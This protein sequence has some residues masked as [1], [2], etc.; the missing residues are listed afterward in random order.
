[1]RANQ[2]INIIKEDESTDLAAGDRFEYGYF[3]QS[4]GQGTVIE[5]IG[6]IG[7]ESIKATLDD[8]RTVKMPYRITPKNGYYIQKIQADAVKEA[9]DES[10]IHAYKAMEA[11][12]GEPTVEKPMLFVK[13]L[14]M[15][16]K[17]AGL[18]N[19][20][21]LHGLVSQYIRDIPRMNRTI[22]LVNRAIESAPSIDEI[23][24]Y[25]QQSQAQDTQFQQQQSIGQLQHELSMQQLIRQND[26]D[27]ADAEAML[28]MDFEAR[29]A[30]KE[31]QQ[32]LSL[33]AQERLAQIE[34]DIRNSREPE[35]ERQQA[36]QMA[37]MNHEHE[38][39]VIQVT[40]DGEY[41]KAKLEADYQIRIKE[42]ENI[43]NARDRQ[44]KL[45]TINANKAKELAVID[46]ETRAKIQSLQA[47]TSAERERADIRVQE[48]FMMTFKPIWGN[49]V[50][51]AS[52]LGRTLGQSIG[53]VT[54][55]LNRL[56]QPTIPQ[57][58]KPA[59]ESID[60]LIE[61]ARR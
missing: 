30:I 22:E 15:L 23:K 57:P 29:R 38:L 36:L 33:Q 61:L 6:P 13:Q 27:K 9:V 35:A 53:S 2:F 51:R 42:L 8:G 19:S 40:A 11:N 26:L 17:D 10:W 41:K 12:G 5:L 50:E 28:V 21:S 3:G 45:E 48:E 20:R 44:S 39:R 49:L 55:A 34:I 58:Q 37:Q 46:A 59:S 56:S 31:R 52:Q 24:R 43:D 60:R 16:A 32:E 25:A 7:Q 47:E 14:A 54:R 1:M 18:T 4:K